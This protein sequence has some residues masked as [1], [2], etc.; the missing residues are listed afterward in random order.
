MKICIETKNDKDEFGIQI[1]KKLAKGAIYMNNKKKKIKWKNI[2]LLVI[3]LLCVYIV[4]HD[5]FML[6][7]YSWI[8]SNLVGWTWFG[9]AIFII[10]LI[11]GGFIID[12]FK[13]EID[14]K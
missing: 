8:T 14:K 6:T 10:A 11:A 2:I 9:L 1:T 3:L 12:F 5:L 4:I 13:K 7:I